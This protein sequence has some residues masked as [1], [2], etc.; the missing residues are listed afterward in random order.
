[1]RNLFVFVL[2]CV[3]CVALADFASCGRGYVLASHAK[4]DGIDAVECQKLW[5]RDL[6][7]NRDMG[8]GNNAARGYRATDS[9]NPICDAT[10]RCVDCWGE[11]VWCKGAD[12]GVWNPEYGAYT[13]TGADNASYTSYL[14]GSCWTWRLG[15]PNCAD[16]QVAI[17]DKETHEWKCLDKV[18]GGAESA[19]KSS[20]RRTGSIR[21]M[22]M[23]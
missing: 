22:L 21:R 5:C 14:N 15:R 8:A 19:L 17:E 13:R 3:P 1:M 2:M 4:I 20:K 16:G 12:V 7:T 9:Y 6:E 11:R 23:K 10:G 18:S